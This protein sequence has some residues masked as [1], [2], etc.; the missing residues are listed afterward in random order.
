MKTM[1]DKSSSSWDKFNESYDQIEQWLDEQ[2]CKNEVTSDDLSQYQRYQR[3]HTQFNDSANFL[4]QI[5][6]QSSCSEIKEKLLYIN[7][8]WKSFQDKFK[9]T[10]LE[11]CLKLYECEHSL[12]MCKERLAKIENLINKN[13]K[14]SLNSVSKYQEEVQKAC[15]DLECLDANLKLISKLSQRIDLR[16]SKEKLVEFTNEIR[17]TETRLAQLKNFMPEY[18]KKLTQIYSHISSIEN[19]LQNIEYW[20]IEGENL[21]RNEPDQLNFDQISKHIEKQK[22]NII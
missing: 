3:I 15:N 1:L 20:V 16:Q 4:L 13:C 11:Q 5:S 10:N 7:K 2:E 21:V 22:V 17:N 18:L 19:G 6:E 14:C 9:D 8:L 12:V